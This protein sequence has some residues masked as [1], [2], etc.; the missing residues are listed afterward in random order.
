[1]ARMMAIKRQFP[2]LLLLG[3]LVVG[4]CANLEVG[5]EGRLPGQPVISGGVCTTTSVGTSTAV[6]LAT[7]GNADEYMITIPAQTLSVTS[8]ATA[9]N[10]ALILE[11]SGSVRG[12]IGHLV[13]HQGNDL[14][15]YRMNL[16]ALAA[17]EGVRARVSSLSAASATKSACLNAVTL[18]SAT[19]L[20]AA[21]E[22]LRNAPIFKWPIKKRFDDLPVLLGWSQSKKTYEA[23]YTNE[24]GGTTSQCG[25]GATGVQ[26][27]IARWGRA[28]DVENIFSYGTS[29]KT[30]F[31]CTG[32][33][34]FS[35]ITPPL[36]GAHP[37]FYYG[38]GHNRLFESR[39]GYGQTCGSGGA[40]K[41]DGDITGWNVSNPGNS[42]AND[43]PYVVIIR[44]VPDALDAIAEYTT[45]PGRRE[46]LPN[47]YGPWLYRLTDSELKREG[48][49]DNSKAFTMSQ[50]LYIDVKTA[51]VGGSGDPYCTFL[52][53]GSGFVQRV[54]T[55]D[56][57]TSNAAQMTADY[58]GAQPGWKRL[59]VP[60]KKSTYAPAD[61]TSLVFDAYD[62]DGIFLLSV[63]EAFIPVNSGTNG[64][65][66]RYV[67]AGVRAINVYVDDN[68]SG[69]V[70]GYNSTGPV[71]GYAYPCR[72]NAYEFTP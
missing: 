37:I 71:S 49:I 54:K 40:E 17:G 62:D 24:N 4:G 34:S 21:G 32:S 18:T 53:V 33:T 1:M 65:T 47:T 23:I 42:P 59:A 29:P 8:W 6:S 60:L 41:S 67:R 19:N 2:G 16:G 58:V 14:F 69:C 15:N 13:L 51:D 26:A 68:N 72:T 9:G 64:A 66:L 45:S 30:W 5:E 20:G 35:S 52:G 70:S 36:E 48:K 39:G 57:L 31:R 44:P 55:S 61:V 63:G 25:G 3:L 12:L 27:E 22:G 11:V 43:G 46:A 10:E 7:A 28:F 38:D 50:Y 56:G